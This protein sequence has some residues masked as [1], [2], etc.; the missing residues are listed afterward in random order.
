MTPLICAIISSNM[1]I[2]KLLVNS[3]NIELE[4]ENQSQKTPIYYAIQV[5]NFEIIRY[6]IEEVKVNCNK[7]DHHGDNIL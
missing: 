1:E 5:K 4:M 7:I 3:K 2:I 6:L